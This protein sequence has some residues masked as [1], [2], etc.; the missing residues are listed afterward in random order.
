MNGLF[1]PS[2]SVQVLFRTRL[3]KVSSIASDIGVSGRRTWRE[4]AREG[5][6]GGGVGGVAILALLVVRGGACSLLMTWL[7]YRTSRNS[8][9]LA[10]GRTPSKGLTSA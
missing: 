10:N 3:R 8:L 6:R 5:G 4:G 1:M 7:H 9:Q 2:T